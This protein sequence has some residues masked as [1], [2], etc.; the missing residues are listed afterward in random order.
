M[1]NHM[2]GILVFGGH[3]SAVSLRNL[4]TTE[5]FGEPVAGS[6]ST[7]IRSYKSIVT[8]EIRAVTNTQMTIWQGRFHD[9]VIRNDADLNRIRAYVI[10]NPARWQEY[11]FYIIP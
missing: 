11:K 9:H 10:N 6:L 4:S 7:V 3:G 8:R 2:H 5:S 1:P